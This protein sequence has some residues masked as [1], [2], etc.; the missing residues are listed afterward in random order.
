MAR[1]WSCS[2]PATIS[3]AE[4]EPPLISTTTGR[5]SVMSPSGL[6]FQRWLSS[7]WRRAGRDDLA[8]VEEVVRHRDRLVQQAARIVAQVEDI[9]LDRLAAGLALSSLTA[10]SHARIG[11]LVEDR[12]GGCSRHRPR[13]RLVGR[14]GIWMTSRSA[15]PR[16]A[17]SAP[18]RLMRQLDLACPAGRASCRRR[19]SASGPA[20]S[21][22]RCA[23]M[24][25]PA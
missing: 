23:V 3:L 11:L 19:R 8:L 13:A 10:V 20:R 1:W 14:P 24:R 7:G 9:A 4:A 17:C 16:S 22:R 18:S 15:S 12:T 5:P 21:C 2:A 25:S 6:A